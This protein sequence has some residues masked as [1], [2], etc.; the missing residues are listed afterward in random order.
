MI[1]E[2]SVAISF[3]SFFL[4]P[5]LCL[6]GFITQRVCGISILGGSGDWGRQIHGD[7][8]AIVLG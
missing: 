1:V 8:P 2:I 7:L 5:E 4:N 6:K 3:L